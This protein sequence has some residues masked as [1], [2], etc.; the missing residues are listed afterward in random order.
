[1]HRTSFVSNR[2]LRRSSPS[3]FETV[4]LAAPRNG[5]GKDSRK[6]DLRREDEKGRAKVDEIRLWRGGHLRAAAAR[7]VERIKGRGRAWKSRGRPRRGGGLRHSTFE[8]RSPTSIHRNIRALF[9]SWNTLG[10]VYLKPVSRPRSDFIPPSIL[11]LYT[12][13]TRTNKF[14]PC[15]PQCF[16]VS[17]V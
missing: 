13:R 5:S 15:S 12:A 4:P 17:G 9:K 1:M 3:K 7:F 14:S 11:E 16:D 10:D 8:C 2:F 6:W